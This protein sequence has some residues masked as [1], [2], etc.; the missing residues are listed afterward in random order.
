[1]TFST[2][3]HSPPAFRRTG[4]VVAALPDD[5][6]LDE[7]LAD[8]ALSSTAKAIVT[9]MIK[10][11]AWRKDH[12]WPS[13][14]TLA[15]KVGKSAGHVQRCLQELEQAGRIA[16]EKTDEVPNG[17]RIWLLWRRPGGRAGAQGV[18]APAREAPSAPARNEQIVVVNEGRELVNQPA[19]SRRRPEATPPA[20][21]DPDATAAPTPSLPVV[22]PPSVPAPSPAA[23]EP[24]GTVV[25]PMRPR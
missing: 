18:S 21:A 24:Q 10:N 8:S 22:E 12:C 1:M 5:P 20:T 16:R 11:W 7:I 13:T 3:R 14:K 9:V 23:Q 17:R 6:G 15:T 19:P 4:R 2:T 25:L